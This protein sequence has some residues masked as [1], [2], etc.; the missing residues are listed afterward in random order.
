MHAAAVSTIQ[1]ITWLHFASFAGIFGI[2][3]Q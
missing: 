1:E 2:V 3:M